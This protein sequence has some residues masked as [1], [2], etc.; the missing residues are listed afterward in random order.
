MKIPFLKWDKVF[1]VVTIPETKRAE[2]KGANVRGRTSE[3]GNA[4]YGI[5]SSQSA[6]IV[7]Q[8]FKSDFYSTLCSQEDALLEI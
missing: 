1:F 3:C 5:S 4:S 8:N 6:E 2:K 7:V